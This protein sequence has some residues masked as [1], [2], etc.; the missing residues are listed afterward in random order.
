MQG[1][2]NVLYLN[3]LVFEFYELLEAPAHLQALKIQREQNRLNSTCSG[4]GVGSADN[5]EGIHS[6]SQ[7]VAGAPRPRSRPRGQGL[8]AAWTHQGVR[9][10]PPR[11]SGRRRLQASV[12]A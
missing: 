8:R 5:E 7:R 10:E 4:V 3:K 12:A 9:G 11:H 1:F 2:Q 6:E